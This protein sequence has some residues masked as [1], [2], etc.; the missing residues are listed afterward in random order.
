M[1]CQQSHK[2]SDGIPGHAC[3][4]RSK[5]AF[6]FFVEVSKEYL[7]EDRESWTQQ[8]ELVIFDFLPLQCRQKPAIPLPPTGTW[9]TQDT[10]CKLV[11]S[12]VRLGGT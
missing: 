7:S 6:P 1:T 9:S 5:L 3:P 8:E 2:G 10:M 11:K 4:Q 12:P